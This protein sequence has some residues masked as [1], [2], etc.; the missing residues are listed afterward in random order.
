[1][2][3]LMLYLL[4]HSMYVPHHS[5]SL[6][7]HPGSFIHSS[8]IVDICKQYGGLH[9]IVEGTVGC[10]QDVS[11]VSQ[12]LLGFS[13][14]SST[15]NLHVGGVETYLARYVQGRVNLY[16]LV[17]RSDSIWCFL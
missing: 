14:C 4:I 6:N 3:L 10:L 9:H 12:G 5:H 11:H 17:V 16:S 7:F 1:M 8:K 2:N 13:N 15:D